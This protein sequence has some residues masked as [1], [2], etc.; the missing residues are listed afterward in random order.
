MFEKSK[1]YKKIEKIILCLVFQDKTPKNRFAVVDHT[2]LQEEYPLSHDVETMPRT[3]QVMNKR[4][5]KKNKKQTET[6]TKTTTTTSSSKTTPKKTIVSKRTTTKAT[7]GVGKTQKPRV[8]K[9]KLT[10][11]TQTITPIPTRKKSTAASTSSGSQKRNTRQTQRVVKSKSK[12]DKTLTSP[13]Q[14]KKKDTKGVPNPKTR[15]SGGGDVDRSSKKVSKKSVTAGGKNWLRRYNLAYARHVLMKTKPGILKRSAKQL[16]HARL[17]VSEKKKKQKEAGSKGEKQHR[18]L[19]PPGPRIFKQGKGK[20]AVLGRVSI[21]K[22]VEQFLPEM[23][24]VARNIIKRIARGTY[25]NMFV[26]SPIYISESGWVPGVACKI[27]VMPIHVENGLEDMGYKIHHP[28]N[29]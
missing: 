10:G 2:T 11:V 25:S 15:P 27:R 1:S 21:E 7:I 6:K 9:N 16:V 26:N 20:V 19:Q 14:K 17:M 13:K 8:V 23:N 4:G 18:Q 12:N 5:V 22:S 29:I 24:H 3:N 28:N